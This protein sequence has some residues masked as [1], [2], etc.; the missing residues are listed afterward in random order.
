MLS[1]YLCFL[2]VPIHWLYTE[3]GGGGLIYLLYRVLAVLIGIY[4][5]L[6]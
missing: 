3:G 6:R 1:E 4:F 5:P 2:C